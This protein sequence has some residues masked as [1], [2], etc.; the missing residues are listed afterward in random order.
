VEHAKGV[1][2]I[3]LRETRADVRQELDQFGIAAEVRP[4]G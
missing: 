2:R 3:P 4:Q 1:V